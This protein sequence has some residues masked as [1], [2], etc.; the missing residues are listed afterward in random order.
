MYKMPI[1]VIILTYNEERNIEACLKSVV[2]FENP[3]PAAQV[4]I[5]GNP[6][7]RHFAVKGHDVS[8]VDYELLVNTT[9]PYEGTY[10]NQSGQVGHQQSTNLILVYDVF[11]TGFCSYRVRPL[12]INY[13]ECILLYFIHEF[14]SPFL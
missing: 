13:L 7:G 8:K 14:L 2:D 11:K 6:A 10:S 3:F 12:L 4:H 5:T 9:D 1:S